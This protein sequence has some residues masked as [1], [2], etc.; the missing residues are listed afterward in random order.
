MFDTHQKTISEYAQ[1]CPDNFAKVHQF[2]LLTIRTPLYRVPQDTKT[3]QRGGPEALAVLWGWKHEAYNHA[4]VHARETLSYLEHVHADATAG[5]HDRT[6]AMLEYLADMPG[7]GLVKA[8]FI[9]QLCYGLGGCLDT[10]NLARFNIPPRTFE[11]FKRKRTIKGRRA[12]IARYLE[13]CD[14]SGGTEALWDTWCEHVANKYPDIYK[15]ADHVSELHCE[16][17]NLT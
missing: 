13:A 2:V 6:G 4:E 16:A 14:K 9:T 8:G 7:L 5:D 3:A 15:N 17:L 12:M 11:G 1:A 10:H